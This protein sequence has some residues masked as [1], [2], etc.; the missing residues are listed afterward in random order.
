M[1]AVQLQM[2]HNIEEVH[3]AI[4]NLN[5]WTSEIERKDATLRGIAPPAGAVSSAATFHACARMLI[6]HQACGSDRSLG[7]DEV[8]RGQERASW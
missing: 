5:S 4:D 7:G 1:A 8:H 3:A 2:R 6:L